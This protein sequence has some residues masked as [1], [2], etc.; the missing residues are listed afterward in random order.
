MRK[1]SDQSKKDDS[2]STFTDSSINTSDIHKN[3]NKNIANRFK[4]DDTE[5]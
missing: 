2:N 5:D 4:Y 3:D 1:V